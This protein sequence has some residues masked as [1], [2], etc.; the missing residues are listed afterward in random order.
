LVRER[1][2]L[3]GNPSLVITIAAE[4]GDFSIAIGQV[5][6]LEQ[7]TGSRR[8][9]FDQKGLSRVRFFAQL[10]LSRTPIAR[11]HL[12][13]REALLSVANAR[14]QKL[15]QRHRPEAFAQLIPTID[16]SRN[17]PTE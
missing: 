2:D 7:I 12:G 8:F 17:R 3:L 5:R 6:V 16:T 14:L 4:L 13:N 1:N 15:I 9:A 10:G 11:D